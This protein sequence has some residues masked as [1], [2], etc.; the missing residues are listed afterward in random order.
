MIEPDEKMAAAAESAAGSRVDELKGVVKHFH[1]VVEAHGRA[2][3][4]LVYASGV[5][6]HGIMILQQAGG[7]EVAQHLRVIA[8]MYNSVAKEL[9]K[10][11]GWREEEI[12]AC[13]RAVRKAMDGKIIVPGRLGGLDS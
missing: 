9:I 4:N 3:F 6:S 7:H 12:N 10:T 5:L 1:P 13:E 8:E 11:K 2:L